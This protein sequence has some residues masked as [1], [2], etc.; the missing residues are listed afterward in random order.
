MTNLSFDRVS[1]FYDFIERYLL[2][3]Y[4]GSMDLVHSL[5]SLSK[6]YRYIDVGGGTGFFSTEIIVKV[7]E[8]VVVD[9]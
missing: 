5:L 9:T 1:F 4:Q 8:V 2:K 6:N 3:D 7:S